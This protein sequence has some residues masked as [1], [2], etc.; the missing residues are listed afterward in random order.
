MSEPRVIPQLRR[1]RRLVVVLAIVIVVLLAAGLFALQAMRAAAQNQ[2][3]AA[4]ENFLGT[5]STV[6]AIVSDAETALAAAETTLADSA[7]KVMV[8]DS[9]VQLAAA[10][11][12]AQQ[13]IATTDSELAGIKSD[14]DAAT[15]QDTG[16]FTMGAGYRDG[17]ETLTSYSSESAEALS[18]VADELAGPVQAVV[19]AVAEWQAEQDRIIA[20]RYNNHVHAVGWIPELDECK[21]SVDLSAQYG[22][23]AIAEHWSC[24]G[25]NFPDEPGQIITLSGERS[26]T[27]RVEGI[28][29]MLNQHTA[30]TADIPHG[31]DLLYQ[32]CQNGQSTTMSLT[33]LTRID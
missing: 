10:I 22:T 19:D 26:G 13:R 20:A 21:G 33:A 24:G 29:K 25:K 18:T 31:Y 32:T 1:P 7:G 12:T 28:I 6:S 3:D 17:A 23:A 14:A 4:Y 15:A 11:D 16:F 8:E 5:Q 30:T 27:Y 2:F 9:R